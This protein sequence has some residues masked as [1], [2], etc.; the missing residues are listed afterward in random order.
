MFCKM[1]Q[2]TQY[3]SIQLMEQGEVQG[4]RREKAERTA[5]RKRGR[6]RGSEGAQGARGNGGAIHLSRKH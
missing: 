4:N 1:E 5:S 2:Q 3:G 6:W